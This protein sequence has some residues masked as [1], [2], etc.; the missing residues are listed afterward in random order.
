MKPSSPELSGPDVRIRDARDDDGPALIEVI[1]GCFAEYPGCILDVEVEAPELKGI[2]S[3]FAGWGGRFWVVEHAGR[4]V[5]C[6]GTTAA[7]DPTGSE[8]KKLYLHRDHRGGTT[9]AALYGTV[10]EE[11]R[12]R[13]SRFVDLWS[14]T[15]F[16]RA[17]R[18]YEKMGF[19]RGDRIRELHDRS[20]S[21]EY[22]FRKNLI[23]TASGADGGD[24]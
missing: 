1:E 13:G 10:E 22:Y 12:R 24:R 15:R 8:L 9:A 21:V 11:A 20:G 18:F 16:R 19:V 17:H 3:A 5:G 7:T 4:V 6:V 2:A 23:A 14:D